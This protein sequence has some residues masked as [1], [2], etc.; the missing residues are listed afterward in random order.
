MQ[1]HYYQ[2]IIPR[3]LYNEL[4]SQFDLQKQ[5]NIAGIEEFSMEESEVDSLLGERSYSGGDVPS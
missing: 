2:A 3:D 1:K 5:F 4:K